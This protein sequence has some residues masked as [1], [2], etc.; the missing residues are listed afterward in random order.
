MLIL[1]QHRLAK[2]Q[3]N[4]K[5]SM[6]SSAP[7]T[8]ITHRSSPCTSIC[9][10]LSIVLIFSLSMRTSLVKNLTHAVHCDF[11][12]CLKIGGDWMLLKTWLQN[13]L[14]VQS[15]HQSGCH[16]SFAFSSQG[17][18]CNSIWRWSSSSIACCDRG[19]MNIVSRSVDSITSTI[20]NYKLVSP[21]RKVKERLSS[22]EEGNHNL[23]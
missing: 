6:V 20:V 5:C 2:G 9:L 15:L 8:H 14:E 11:H 23:R 21:Q 12:I 1:A 4:N 7:V 17:T 19:R 22:I 16:W 18:F 3:V 13:F 10:L